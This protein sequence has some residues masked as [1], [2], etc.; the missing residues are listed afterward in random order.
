MFSAY[1]KTSSDAL[2]ESFNL[3]AGPLKTVGLMLRLWLTDSATG[4]KIPIITFTWSPAEHLHTNL[5][6]SFCFSQ[7]PIGRK[8]G[9]QWH[10]MVIHRE[11]QSTP[12][13]CATSQ[14][15]PAQTGTGVNPHVWKPDHFHTG[16]KAG[17][18]TWAQA[19]KTLTFPTWVFTLPVVFAVTPYPLGGNNSK[20]HWPSVCLLICIACTY[21]TLLPFKHR[22]IFENCSVPK[23]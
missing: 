13:P 14:S 7:L 5:E 16:S 4:S 18:G 20:C 17:T 11:I 21:F 6:L 19:V 12:M 2:L 10:R 3:R 22:Q 15:C 23:L 8:K 9:Y 1:L